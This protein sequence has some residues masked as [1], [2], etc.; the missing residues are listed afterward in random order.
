M[1][2]KREVLS[3]EVTR[4]QK[5]RWRRA[6]KRVG[7]SLSSWVRWVLEQ[8]ARDESKGEQR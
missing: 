5:L 6:A 1:A 4:S 8:A 2:E 3:V 7:R